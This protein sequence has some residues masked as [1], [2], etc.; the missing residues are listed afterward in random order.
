MAKNAVCLVSHIKHQ[1]FHEKSV[2]QKSVARINFTSNAQYFEADAEVKHGETVK[3]QSLHPWMSIM[4]GKH[5]VR[6]CQ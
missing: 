3:P 2:A 5:H 1:S 4:Y 6:I